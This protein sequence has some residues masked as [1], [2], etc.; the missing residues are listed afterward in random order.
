MGAPGVRDLGC[1]FG[2]NGKDI[3]RK[4]SRCKITSSDRGSL[5]KGHPVSANLGLSEEE[6]RKITEL[7]KCI[8]DAL[9][10]V[11][12][13]LGDLDKTLK[14]LDSLLAGI[15]M[16]GDLASEL[17]RVSSFTLDPYP[18]GDYVEVSIPQLES[19]IGS[20][21]FFDGFRNITRILRVPVN[22]KEREY[23][24]E[25]PLY[26]LKAGFAATGAL[27]RVM[28]QLPGAQYSTVGDAVRHCFW[29][30]QLF[31]D[32]PP[33]V[34]QT[35]LDNHEF[36]RTD[37]IDVHNNAVGRSIGISRGGSDNDELWN[38]C[39]KAASDGRLKIPG[40]STNA[41]QPQVDRVRDTSPPVRDR[42]AAGPVRA[43]VITDRL[44]RE[45]EARENAAREREARE[46]EAREREGRDLERQRRERERERIERENR[47]SDGGTIVGG[48]RL[49]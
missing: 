19:T 10:D 45:R 4:T 23:F 40:S 41:P 32:L 16:T 6:M 9:R 24:R 28:S 11:N 31:R 30:S 33:E 8:N 27:W 18:L 47:R 43:E 15:P 39:L 14:E 1:R 5:K 21:R 35:I 25:H 7:C 42:N 36:G 12:P 38:E 13:A 26:S 20:S 2:S 29:S 22:E 46:R 34:A 37:E 44:E 48:G 17:E 49:P 3:W